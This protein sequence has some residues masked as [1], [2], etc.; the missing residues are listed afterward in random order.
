[1]ANSF[2][3]NKKN[4]IRSLSKYNNKEKYELL[5]RST[6]VKY[7]LFSRVHFGTKIM[8]DGNSIYKILGISAMKI[9]HSENKVYYKL[10]GL[11]PILKVRSIFN[12]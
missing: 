11:L 6:I 5:F 4:F 12:S 10:F 3:E 9:C 8:K 7:Y 1:M 2:L